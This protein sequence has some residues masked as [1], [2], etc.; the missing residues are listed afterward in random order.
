MRHAGNVPA[1]DPI[2]LKRAEL[3]AR[4]R[5][6]LNCDDPVAVSQKV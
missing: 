3:D 4:R 1:F 5:G 2:A 6:K